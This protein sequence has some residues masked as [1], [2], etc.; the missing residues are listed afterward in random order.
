MGNAVG[1]TFE[2]YASKNEA[3]ALAL[4]SENPG[5]MCF[6]PDKKSIVFNGEVY[7]GDK[8]T[9]WQKE[10]LA[11]QEQ[12]DKEARFSLAVALNPG[13]T[14]VKGTSTKVTVTVTAKYDN[15]AKDLSALKGTGALADLTSLSQFTKKGTGVYTAEKTITA[16]QT[17]GVQGTYSGITKSASKTIQAYSLIKYGCSTKATL[18][19]GD[20]AGLGS[21]GPQASAAG[22]YGFTFPANSYAYVC[23]PE[24]VTIP[25][26]LDGSQPQGAEGPLPVFFT[27]QGTVASGGITYTVFRIADMQAASTHTI[28]FS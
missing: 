1:Q 25:G 13:A 7:G 23:I 24:G 19:A 3:D 14:F 6:T 22:E 9:D 5:A 18:A 2:V 4:A 11:G 17:F 27:K 10:Y 12:A 26:S 20:I 21:K 8:L 15:A 16:G 28:K